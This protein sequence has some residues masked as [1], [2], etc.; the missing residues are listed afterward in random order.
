MATT[1]THHVTQTI[2]Q[3]GLLKCT[4]QS[5][6]MRCVCIPAAATMIVLKSTSIHFNDLEIDLLMLANQAS[7]ALRTHKVPEIASR[8][9]FF[10]LLSSPKFWRRIESSGSN[11]E[12]LF[13]RL[14]ASYNFVFFEISILLEIGW[15]H[16][17][18]FDAIRFNFSHFIC[19]GRLDL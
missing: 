6:Y 3:R 16:L 5:K 17:I 7:S 19:V 9:L 10:H 15:M 14:P 11:T 18:Q 1:A 4:D 12:E 2:K 13:R 8:V